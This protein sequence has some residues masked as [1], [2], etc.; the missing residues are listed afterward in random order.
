MVAI[1]PDS[2]VLPSEDN[3]ELSTVNAQ[4][5]LWGW[6]EMSCSQLRSGSAPSFKQQHDSCWDQF[7]ASVDQQ[8]RDHYAIRAELSGQVSGSH[9]QQGAYWLT[10]KSLSTLV[11]Y[12]SISKATTFGSAHVVPA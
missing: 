1:D 4:G 2:Q 3:V 11:V 6:N 10:I 5:D 12:H 9:A 8:V 7:V